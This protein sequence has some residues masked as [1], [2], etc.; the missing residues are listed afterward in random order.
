MKSTPSLRKVV[1]QTPL[2]T[3]AALLAAVAFQTQPVSGQIITLQDQNSVAQVNVGSSAG[4]FNWH[5]DGVNQLAQQW[6]WYRVGSVGGEL[7][8]N[9]LSAPVVVTPDA[10]T[11]Y[12]TYNNGAFSIEV[13]Y[14]L[15]GGL[16]GSGVADIGE[17]IRI[18]NLTANP[19]NFHFFQYCDFDLAGTAGGDATLLKFG[20]GAFYV[21]GQNEGAIALEEQVNTPAASHGQAGFFPVVLN[22]LNDGVATT[23]NDNPAAG[24]GDTAYALQW[25]FLLGGNSSFLISKDK[26]ISLQPIPEPATFALVSLGLM[27]LSLRKRR[28]D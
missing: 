24:V 23:L 15:T 14:T 13:D 20:P 16:A 3:V 22:L 2:S 28:Q 7:P 19:L 26:R 6:F 5:V 12:T 4:M 9:T 21:A 25:D 10:R 8:I 1:P 27:A 18:N 11:L 17:S